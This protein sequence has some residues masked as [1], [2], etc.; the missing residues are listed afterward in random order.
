MQNKLVI[1]ALLELSRDIMI[2]SHPEQGYWAIQMKDASLPVLMEWT[3]FKTIAQ[4]LVNKES[5][6][7]MPKL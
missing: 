5:G 2:S 7:E 3:F 4:Q 6:Y 1:Q